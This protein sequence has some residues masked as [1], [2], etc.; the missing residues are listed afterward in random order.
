M[1]VFIIILG[2]SE[3][4]KEIIT[5]LIKILYSFKKYSINHTHFLNLFFQNLHII[6]HEFLFS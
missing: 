4:K 1:K 5:R 6:T 2:F 3:Y